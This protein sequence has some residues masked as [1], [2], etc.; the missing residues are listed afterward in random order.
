[1]FCLTPCLQFYQILLS[2]LTGVFFAFVFE[3]GVYSR[4]T[5]FY[6]SRGLEKIISIFEHAERYSAH[7]SK[8]VAT[9]AYYI[10]SRAG[11]KRKELKDLRIAALL[12]DIGKISIPKSILNKPGKLNDE[13]FEIVKKHPIYSAEIIENFEELSHLSYYIRH[14][15]EKNDGSGYPAG[16]KGNEIPLFCKIIAVA[17]IFEA[18]IGVR[19]Y[20]DPIPPREAIHLMKTQMSVDPFILKILSLELTRIMPELKLDAPLA[21]QPLISL[22]DISFQTKSL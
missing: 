19:P 2:L 15:H 4:I 8:N 6:E 3:R 22:E 1:M 7:H 10:G 16:L 13:E 20:R 12:H 17:D 18:L 9:I 21:D 11:L 5:Y 14:H